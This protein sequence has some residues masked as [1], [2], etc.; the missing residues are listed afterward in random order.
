[1]TVFPKNF[2][3]IAK[4]NGRTTCHGQDYEIALSGGEQLP[5]TFTALL[6]AR[7]RVHRNPDPFGFGRLGV[8]LRVLFTYELTG[9]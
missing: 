4:D 2:L 8:G 6:L 3:A 1:M 9:P 7:L 5:A